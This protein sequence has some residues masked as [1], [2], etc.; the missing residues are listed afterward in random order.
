METRHPVEV[1][2]DEEAHLVQ[3]LSK[4]PGYRLIVPDLNSLG[5]RLM[6]RGCCPPITAPPHG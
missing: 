3:W 4:H 2:A 6:G 1:G 5:F